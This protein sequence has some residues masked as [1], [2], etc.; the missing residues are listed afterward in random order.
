[1]KRRDF[2]K[3]L[4]LSS[5]A[6]LTASCIEGYHWLGTKSKNLIS[7]VDDKDYIPGVA[8]YQTTTCMECPAHCGV[9]VKLI[10]GTP[11]KLEGNPQHPLSQGALCIRGQASL[12][13]LHHPKRLQRP[14]RRQGEEFI[15]IS[16]KDAYK[17]ITTSIQ[18]AKQQQKK[19]LFLSRY[20]TGTL[21]QLINLFCKTFQIE[22]RPDFEVYCHTPLRKANQILFGK[23]EIPHFHIEKSD[24]LLTIGAD[25]LE[26]FL[27]PMAFSKQFA[28]AKTNQPHW[29][30]THIEPHSSL[31]GMR[32]SKRLRL[33]PKSEV[34]LLAYLLHDLQKSY[35]HKLNP[36]Q[37]APA[38]SRKQAAQITQIPEE[39][40]QL[41]SQQL[42]NAKSPLLIT[43]GISTEHDLGLEVALLSS[44]LQWALGMTENT[45]DFSQSFLYTVPNYFEDGKDSFVGN[46]EDIRELSQ[47]LAQKKVGVLF[48]CQ[49]NP[50]PYLPNDFSFNA[51]LSYASLKV[52]MSDFLD[53]TMQLCDLV[54]PTSHYLESIGDTQ[55][56]RHLRNFLK[57]ILPP[58]YQTKTVGDIL[59]GIMQHAPE[60]GGARFSKTYQAY[61]KTTHPFKKHE[62]ET[63]FQQLSNQST[64]LTL[65]LK[66]LPKFLQPKEWE[67]YQQPSPTLIIPPSLR[68]FDGRSRMIP[69]L[70]EI[71][72][73]LTSVSWDKWISISYKDAQKQHIQNGDEILL[74][75]GDLTLKLP[76]VIQAGLPSG[77]LLYHH[78]Q[79]LASQ[80]KP[81]Q[82]SGSINSYIQNVNFQKT[83]KTLPLSILSGSMDQTN[84]HILP[85]TLSQPANS[86][87]NG[88][89]PNHK[90]T[91][92][93]TASKEQHHNL[94]PP[95]THKEYRWAMAID[96]D[97]CNGCSA[98]VAA[99]YIENNIPVVGKKEHLLGR[100]MSWIRIE[101]YLPDNTTLDHDVHFVPMLCQQCDNAPCESVCPVYATMHS[102][103]G[104]NQ[105]VYNRCV[106]TRYC[107]NN[108][109]YKVRRFNWFDWEG[110]PARPLG[111]TFNPQVFVR[112]RGIMEKCTFCVHRIRTARD[113]AKDQ[114]RKIQDGE[115]TPACAESCP[116]NAITFGNILDKQSKVYR[117]AHSSH[118]HRIFEELGVQ[119]SIYYLAKG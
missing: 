30:W 12:S 53:E 86:K 24:F 119:P 16:W 103:D 66:E 55:S 92:H 50:T 98:C 57:P 60:L 25:I 38:I 104:L 63:G 94:Y 67:K 20:T 77:V 44:L 62:F 84:R 95:H 109:P 117:L 105:Q 72:D 106:G 101:P 1:M 39:E 59:L 110:W 43:G 32:A 97:L 33:Q 83:S 61:L 48:L 80:L 21:C 36:N 46:L 27:Q 9:K 15:E 26:T 7:L 22:R 17:L 23:Q 47:L 82:K 68:H 108:C 10:D 40:L 45:I 102:S 42:A 51:N 71:P 112:S 114:G 85:P 31:T 65:N 74:K 87:H 28:Q 29:H 4:G 100:E 37:F 18:E 89:Q 70:H 2:L 13:R 52:G 115:I 41:L 11:L 54:L 64:K 8:Y 118:S 93:H 6:A 58:K 14:L 69:L 81:L 79:D 5:T 111:N 3:L 34:Y 49:T 56:N 90:N 73:P 113:K 96:L 75:V 19:N 88:K 78:R 107:S 91:Q 35:K 116:T 76:A 99:C